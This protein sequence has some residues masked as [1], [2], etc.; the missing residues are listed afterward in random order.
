MYVYSYKEQRRA[1]S[2]VYLINIIIEVPNF[3]K[4]WPKISLNIDEMSTI[5][6]RCEERHYPKFFQ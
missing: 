1:E 3:Q 6:L 5:V 2:T 4:T